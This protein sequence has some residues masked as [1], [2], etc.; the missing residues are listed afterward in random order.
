MGYKGNKSFRVLN[1]FERLNKGE[2]L[3]KNKLA[4]EFEV[5]T[6]TIQRDIES[7]REYLA[8]NAYEKI[9]SNLKYKKSDDKYDLIRDEESILNNKE[10][11]V[12]CK[13]LLES[14]ALCKEEMDVLINKLIL[15]VSF[16][17]SKKV[18]DIISNE[19]FHYIQL[20]HGKKL[21]EPLW[22]LLDLISKKE[23]IKFD[24]TRQD[25]VKKQKEAKPVAIMF[26]E[27]YFYLLAYV[28]NKDFPIV[29][30]VDR[31]ENLKS[32]NE[33]FKLNEK[34]RFEEGEFR[35]R[36]Q[37]MYSGELKQIKFKYS[38]YSIEAILDRI[39]TA[40]IIEKVEDG[41]ILEAE[42]YGDGILM[43]LKTQGSKVEILSK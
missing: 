23:I 3:D 43:W 1:I 8:A 16:K 14:R 4:S 15:Q 29:F 42:T 5:S 18:K 35:K 33:H 40:K 27:F 38:G 2:S 17:D 6:K 12:L 39:P 41:I 26:S 9:K 32:K 11:M 37:F 24:Y 7:V 34:D 20:K 28:E 19:Q 36:V 25:G 22:N 31:I 13:I 21:I 10:V 30:R